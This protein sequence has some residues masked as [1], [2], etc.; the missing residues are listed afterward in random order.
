[1]AQTGFTP[2]ILFHSTT[3]SNTPTTG[4]LAVGELAINNTDG[5]LYY[6]TGSAVALLASFNATAGIFGG[7][8][9]ITIPVGTTG[10]QPASPSTGMLRFN[11]SLVQFEGYNGSVWT[12]VGGGA[13]GGGT[14]QVFVLNGVTVTTSYTFPTGKNAETVGPI[15]INSGAVVTV[16]SGQRWVV[17]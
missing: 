9:A 4:N 14:D 15:T 5:K 17:L 8:G 11:S 1:M 6:N 10:Q 13:T 2:I 12:S 7:T 16:P 3:A